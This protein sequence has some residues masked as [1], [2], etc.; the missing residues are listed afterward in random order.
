MLSLK[1]ETSFDTILREYAAV[2]P[3]GI[4]CHRPRPALT[5]HQPQPIG[6]R[7]YSTYLE[8]TV[9]GTPYATPDLLLTIP[10]ALV[11]KSHRSPFCIDL[12]R[13]TIL[14]HPALDSVFSTP[15]AHWNQTLRSLVHNRTVSVPGRALLLDAR[16]GKEFF[17]FT[18][19][20]LGR[21]RTYLGFEK[22]LDAVDFFI[23][24]E[25]S[26]WVVAWADRARLPPSKRLYLG[27]ATG[28]QVGE[29][30]VPSAP[31]D[32]DRGTIA[33]I[34]NQIPL[35]PVAA[36]RRIFISR[37]ASPNGRQI[38]NE[39]EVVARVLE[40]RGFEVVRLEEFTLPEQAAIMASA[41]H[42]VAAHGGGLTNLVFCS[43]GTRVLEVF[44]PKWIVFCYAR[45]A[46]LLGI[47]S[48]Y[49]V[50]ERGADR[51]ILLDCDEFGD[52]LDA[53][54]SR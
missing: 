31:A 5:W 19:S 9:P 10:N 21:L 16:Y 30:L 29:L 11:V 32:F 35:E 39:A 48:Y 38:L 42:V 13:R 25:P 28:V 45:L 40:P 27:E 50:C 47:P 26:P 37:S 8:N 7:A 24:P 12:A 6:C 4:P 51:D 14:C 1:T 17:H 44:G 20:V 52:V 3:H 22:L 36:R 43:P 54:L 34:R 53:F 15:P 23:L 2:D 46:N 49:H 33:Y 41:K 18:T